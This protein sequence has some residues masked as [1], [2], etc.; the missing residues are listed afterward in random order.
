MI[1]DERRT[2]DRT[3]F[4]ALGNLRPHWSGGGSLTVRLLAERALD[5]TRRHARDL[6]PAIT[7]MC[8]AAG[9]RLRVDGVAPST[10][11][12]GVTPGCASASC[13]PRPWPGRR[14]ALPWASNRSPPSCGRRSQALHLDVLDDAQQQNIYVQ[15]WTRLPSGWR[16]EPL[17]I[18][19]AAEWLEDL[20]PGIWVTGPGLL[21]YE[22]RMP[23]GNPLVAGPRRDPQP[24]SLLEIALERWRRG[25]LTPRCRTALL[26]AQQ[27]RGNR[28][29][30]GQ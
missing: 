6:V 14:L 21:P 10:S 7:D 27:R 22:A 13:P 16:N 18:R 1:R 3:A 17:R 26:A 5:E 4:A 11:G 24:A 25:D 2:I 20:E 15:R 8:A 28:D 19:R 12:P 23:P 29:A 30:N 9:W